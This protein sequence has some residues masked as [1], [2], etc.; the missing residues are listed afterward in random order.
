VL[1]GRA[2]LVQLR[3]RLELRP[4]QHA[5]HDAA[6]DGLLAELVRQLALGAEA[7]RLQ[8]HVLLGLRVEGGVL[9]QAVDKQ[10]HVVLDLRAGRVRQRAQRKRSEPGRA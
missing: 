9:D 4:L 6:L 2:L 5:V 3:L 1:G 8:R 7:L 10:P